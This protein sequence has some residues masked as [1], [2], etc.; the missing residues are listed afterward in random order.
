M[1][2][3]GGIPIL[4]DEN[5]ETHMIPELT[6][7]PF[8]NRQ[9]WIDDMDPVSQQILWNDPMPESPENKEHNYLKNRRGLGYLF[10]EHIFRDFC[11]KNKVDYVF[12][13]HQVYSEGIHYDFDKRFITIVSTSNY[14]GKPI[15]ARFVEVDSTDIVNQ[16]V[17]SIQDLSD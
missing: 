14:S 9:I 7:T 10:G 16:K 3:H 2:F 12:R 8:N 15:H 17:H 5:K 1:A 11:L 6:A 4:V 13:G